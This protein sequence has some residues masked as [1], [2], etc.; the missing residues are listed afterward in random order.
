MTHEYTV[1]SVK[2]FRGMEGRG[3]NA[4]LCRAGVPVALVIDDASGG[5]YQFEWKDRNAKQVPVTWSP[6]DNGE[7]FTFQASPEEA[8]LY[9]TSLAQPKV[10]FYRME[11]Q[12][13]PDMFVGQLLE[14]FENAKREKRR[15]K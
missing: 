14:G 10:K 9:E 15:A 3:F 7:M 6:L 1:T 11:L 8:K 2:T 13:T 5:P 4:T 12:V